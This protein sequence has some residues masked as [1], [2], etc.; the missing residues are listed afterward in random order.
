MGEKSVSEVFGNCS[1]WP[2]ICSEINEIGMTDTVRVGRNTLENECRDLVMSL[3]AM[4]TL[5]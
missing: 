3:L 1:A 5:I 4:L 2:G